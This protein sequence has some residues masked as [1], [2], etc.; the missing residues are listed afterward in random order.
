MIAAVTW[1]RRGAAKKVPKTFED[2]APDEEEDV[3][4][5]LHLSRP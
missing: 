2:I 3:G 4:C 1:A 5:A